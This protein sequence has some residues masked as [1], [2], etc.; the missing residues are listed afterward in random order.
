[1]IFSVI[2][3]RFKAYLSNV[4]LFVYYRPPVAVKCHLLRS[5]ARSR[6]STEEGI[7]RYN[8]RQRSLSASIVTQLFQFWVHSWSWG[9]SGRLDTLLEVR[10]DFN[11]KA[12]TLHDNNNCQ[13][14][15]NILC[16]YKLGANWEL[17]YLAFPEGPIE[18]GATWELEA[19]IEN[20]DGDNINLIFWK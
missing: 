14:T 6:S 8:I 10:S 20:I 7:R 1:M 19:K 18:Y 3:K 12:E 2:Y 9:V 17:R 11:L 16:K 15:Q 4:I 13:G 5:V